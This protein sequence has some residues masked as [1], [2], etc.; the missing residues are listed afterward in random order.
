MALKGESKVMPCRGKPTNPEHLKRRL[1]DVVEAVLDGEILFCKQLEAK[2]AAWL[3]AG[4][5]HWLNESGLPP[6]KA[7][8][9]RYIRRAN[10]TIGSYA[11]RNPA[12][13]VATHRAMRMSLLEKAMAGDRPDLGLAH[14]ILRDL[15]RLDGAYPAKH[16][17]VTSESRNVNVEVSL[18]ERSALAQLAQRL[19]FS[20]DGPAQGGQ[21]AADGRLLDGPGGDLQG[22][23]ADAGPVA[24]GGAD[25][26]LEQLPPVLL[27]AG[28]QE[29]G[30]GGAGDQDDARGG[31][32]AGGGGRAV[33]GPVEGVDPGA[34]HATDGGDRLAGAAVEDA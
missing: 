28:G 33:G 6:S 21:P 1:A 15:G 25:G 22:V 3:A 4:R 18:D 2:V 7:V 12:Q 27:A 31:P 16:L 29:P 17:K 8:L 9:Y 32:G 19:G 24:A 20:L 34:R 11:S 30:D 26:W 10:A 5:T 23:W 14:Q 13:V